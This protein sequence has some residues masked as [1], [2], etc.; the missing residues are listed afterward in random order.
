M[1]KT[2]SR[3]RKATKLES[4]QAASELPDF[5]ETNSP[6]DKNAK[7]AKNTKIYIFN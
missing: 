2:Q 7:N 5:R 3:A 6:D 4:K 1:Y